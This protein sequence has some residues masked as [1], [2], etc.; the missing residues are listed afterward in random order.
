MS[1]FDRI[2]TQ[3]ILNLLAFIYN[4]VTDFGVAIIILTIIVRLAMWPLVKKSIHQMKLMRE[5]QPEL[6]K[7]KKKAKGNRMLE[8]TMMMALYKK[9]NVKPFASIATMIVQLPVMIAIFRVIQIFSG[10]TYN[11]INH[12]NANDFIYPF[13]QKFGH[14]PELLDP[15]NLSLFNLVDL[16]KV[17]NGYLPAVMIAILAAGFQFLQSRQTMPR[18]N[19]GKSVRGMLKEAAN[20]KEV[21][22]S[23]LTMA[24]TSKMIYF[25]PIMTFMI[26]LALPGAVV[27]YYAVTSAF[28]LVQQTIMLKNNKSDNDDNSNISKREKEALPAEI[29]VKPKNKNSKKSKSSANNKTVVRRLKAK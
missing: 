18:N 5:I 8:S 20:G 11:S 15:A 6:A 1:L 27:L 17:T 9:H 16:S 3:P 28:A 4:F 10:S 22:Q 12:T 14:I 23:E 19:K 7:I 25:F 13:L 21:D 2:L 26:A 29:V 24:A